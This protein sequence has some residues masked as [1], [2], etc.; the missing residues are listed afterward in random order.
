M[1]VCMCVRVCVCECVYVR[2]FI[3]YPFHLRES[4]FICLYVHLAYVHELYILPTF[5][6]TCTVHTYIVI[7]ILYNMYCYCT[8]AS[9]Y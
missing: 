3:Y 8:V 5:N 9:N 2:E 7:Y 4:V 6:T 1:C